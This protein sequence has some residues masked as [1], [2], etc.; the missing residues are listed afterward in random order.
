MFAQP[1]L[2]LTIRSI[3][4]FV[5]LLISDHEFVIMTE[6]SQEE[7]LGPRGISR[8]PCWAATLAHNIDCVGPHRVDG[9]RN[10]R[11]GRGT[12]AG[13]MLPRFRPVLPEDSHFLPRCEH[14]GE[15]FPCFGEWGNWGDQQ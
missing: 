8:L 13:I 12:C 7:P 9:T 11:D 14:A 5:T 6:V 15:V 2:H 1:A 10:Y 4:Q 3:F